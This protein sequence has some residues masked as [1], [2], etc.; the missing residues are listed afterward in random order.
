MYQTPV[1][2]LHPPALQAL[3]RM[4]EE[5]LV[6]DT[7]IRGRVEAVK[8]ALEQTQAS[9]WTTRIEANLD[10]PE[11]LELLRK[12]RREA[13]ILAESLL[14]GFY[15]MGDRLNVIQRDLFE[16]IKVIVEQAGSD[17]RHDPD[18][19][20]K[21]ILINTA[22]RAEEI[23]RRRPI[24]DDARIPN[25]IDAD[26]DQASLA[27]LKSA[28]SEVVEVVKSLKNG[29]SLTHQDPK[30]SLVYLYPLE[31]AVTPAAL[32]KDYKRDEMR[33]CPVQPFLDTV[34]DKHP[35]LQKLSEQLVA[36][37]QAVKKARAAASTHRSGEKGKVNERQY[38][39]RLLSVL[40]GTPGTC[41]YGGPKAMKEEQERQKGARLAY[42]SQRVVVYSELVAAEALRREVVAT[43]RDAVAECEALEE[44][45]CADSRATTDKLFTRRLALINCIAA[46]VQL[47]QAGRDLTEVA[48]EYDT[49]VTSGK[50]ASQTA[51]E[52]AELK[53]YYDSFKPR[54]GDTKSGG[55]SE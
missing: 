49:D 29:S 11:G 36:L 15:S 46:D 37:E 42:Q 30:T 45:I 48:K 52:F 53:R 5:A 7:D 50:G 12:E 3:E 51:T 28:F 33:F 17:K 25:R 19:W 22:L 10:N 26:R 24:F 54:E 2:Q 47:R 40:D 18:A 8:R 41:G 43:L 6:I 23:R 14:F 20:L 34:N 21:P 13:L 9:A 31:G 38:A 39:N 44:Q 32:G 16:A 55:A 35:A 1:Q 27:A 4:M